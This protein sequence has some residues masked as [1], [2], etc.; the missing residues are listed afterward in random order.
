MLTHAH[1]H[2]MFTHVYAIKT[3]LSDNGIGTQYGSG[4][5]A[6]SSSKHTAERQRQRYPVWVRNAR[7]ISKQNTAEL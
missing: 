5:H 1:V 3:Q 7:C 4:M 2:N 6:A